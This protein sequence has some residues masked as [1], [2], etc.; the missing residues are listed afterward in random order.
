MC[1]FQLVLD[2]Q[3]G[4][5]PAAIRRRSGGDPAAKTA[6]GWPAAAQPSG[7]G[8]EEERAEGMDLAGSLQ[9]ANGARPRP[10]KRRHCSGSPQRRLQGSD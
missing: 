9:D 3:I 4:G 1:A 6:P 2:G 8:W 7:A 10:G 5:D